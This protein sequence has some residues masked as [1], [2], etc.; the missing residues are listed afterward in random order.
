M[1]PPKADKEC[2]TCMLHVLD[3]FLSDHD[4]SVEIGWKRKTSSELEID[5]LKLAPCNILKVG[6]AGTVYMYVRVYSLIVDLVSISY[7]DSHTQP[8]GSCPERG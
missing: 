4:M 5:S 2:Q 8:G 1:S 7:P 6:G 3:K